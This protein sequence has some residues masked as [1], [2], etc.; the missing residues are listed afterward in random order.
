MGKVN[1]WAYMLKIRFLRHRLG[2]CERA[3][4]PRDCEAWISEINGAKQTRL[5]LIEPSPRPASARREGSAR[6]RRDSESD[7]ER[8][9]APLPLPIGG[10]LSVFLETCLYYQFCL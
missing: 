4:T 3:R 1:D 10:R 8:S 6:G 2:L 9:E 7:E 5:N